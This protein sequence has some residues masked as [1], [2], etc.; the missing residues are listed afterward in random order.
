MTVVHTS[1]WRTAH[2]SAARQGETSEGN[3]RTSRPYRMG[4]HRPCGGTECGN[5]SQMIT[6]MV[7]K[8]FAPTAT[9]SAPSLADR[10]VTEW[11]KGAPDAVIA[12][13][14]GEPLES[15]RIAR[16]GRR[17]TAHKFDRRKWAHELTPEQSN[18]RHRRGFRFEQRKQ[19]EHH[20]DIHWQHRPGAGTVLTRSRASPVWRSASA[21]RSG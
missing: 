19:H 2:A 11:S 3:D 15:V 13:R 18:P 16:R 6:G 9:G 14:L 21:V 8:A 4:A 17:L 5:L 12:H 10:V 20:S 1:G 7:L